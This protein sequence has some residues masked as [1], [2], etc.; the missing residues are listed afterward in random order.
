MRAWR[1]EGNFWVR[2][3][4]AP[5][6]A[7]DDF[8]LNVTRPRFYSSGD[9]RN[10]VGCYPGVPRTTVTGVVQSAGAVH[11]NLTIT[12]KVAITAP[13]QTFRNCR[14]TFSST[15][16]GAGGLLQSHN[17]QPHPTLIE[18]CEFEPDN[19][20]DRYNGLYGHHLT[21]IR[22]A[23]RRCVDGIGL[24]NPSGGP[25]D[26]QIL[27]CWIGYNSWY[28][29]DRYVDP[30]GTSFPGGRQWGHSDGSHNDG[31]QAGGSGGGIVVH[32]NFWQQAKYNGLNPENV[33]LNEDE[34]YT[35]NPGNGITP[36]SETGANNSRPQ[37][38]QCFLG[39]A[40]AY[41]PFTGL[42]FQHNWVW[43]GDNG[44]LLQVGP[45]QG[46]ARIQATVANNI[47]GGRW[48]AQGSTTKY[49]ALYYGPRTDM[50]GETIAA[51][52]KLDTWGNVWAD[53]VHE[54]MTDTRGYVGGLPVYHRYDPA[55]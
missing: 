31:I 55:H 17:T 49:R 26:S 27:G 24:Y 3:G 54:S 20:W 5:I 6:I 35:L 29:D 22:C 21:V 18:R 46:A 39:N 13:N 52:A 23:I 1:K 33:V 2:R 42:D 14:F 41:G 10:N 9:P 12:G 44:I 25:I 38:G 51:D 40:A 32:G 15:G 36:L 50:N 37:S 11:E 30:A 34:S 47:F 28:Y 7:G 53:D 4:Q 16:D 19:P 48:R 43:N 45:A 8:V